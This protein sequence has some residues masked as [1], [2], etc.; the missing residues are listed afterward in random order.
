MQERQRESQRESQREGQRHLRRPGVS[1]QRIAQRF[2]DLVRFGLLRVTIRAARLLSGYRMRV[3]ARPQRVLFICEDAI[4]DLILTLPAI[5]AIAE[6]RP[7]TTVDLVTSDYSADLVRHVPYIR[8][9]ILFPRHEKHRLTAAF[10]IL[11]DGPYDA[12]V[13]GM[14]MRSH[15]RTRS[16]AMMVGARAPVWIGE[17]GK[18]NDH[19]YTI[20][21]PPTPAPVPHAERMMRLAHPFL[22]AQSRPSLRA[23]L[24]VTRGERS[25]A[26]AMWATADGAGDRILV[27]LSASCPERRWPDEHF[28][29]V[30]ERIRALRRTGPLIVVGLPRDADSVRALAGSVAALGIVP[31]L[32]ELLALVATAD[33]IVSPDTAVCHMASAFERTL[34]SLNLRDHEIWAPYETPGARVIGPSDETLEGLEPV[35]VVDAVTFV[36]RGRS[37]RMP[38]PRA[39]SRST[40][41]GGR[42]PHF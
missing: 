28:A 16:V 27:N 11:R 34:V 41:A 31:T 38:A 20:A 2:E 18:T 36:L 4:G 35:D 25:I 30:L 12:V 37:D 32:R 33:V 21:I 5:R 29:V 39:A 14:V 23:R 10:T 9:V 3:A 13:D 7:G 24:E 19:A 15:V 8:R 42:S 40:L 1:V 26:D 22:S 6:S 17:S